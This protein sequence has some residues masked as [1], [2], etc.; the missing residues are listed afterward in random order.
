MITECQLTQRKA[1]KSLG[2]ARSTVACKDPT[3]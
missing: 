3:G 2:L 1:C